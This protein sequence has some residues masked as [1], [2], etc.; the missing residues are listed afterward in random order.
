MKRFLERILLESNDNGGGAEGPNE[1]NLG[2]EDI[3][4]FDEKD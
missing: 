1:G 3:Y 4:G 2:P